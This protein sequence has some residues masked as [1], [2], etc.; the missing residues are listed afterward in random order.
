MIHSP[1]F[2]KRFKEKPEVFAD[3]AKGLKKGDSFSTFKSK[4]RTGI[5]NSKNQG[6]LLKMSNDQLYEMWTKSISKPSIKAKANTKAELKNFKGQA[7]KPKII[8]VKRKGKAYKRTV[9]KRW[10]RTTVFGIKTAS[11]VKPKSKE[12][13]SYVASIVKATG[14]TRQAVVK[15]I[16]RERRKQQK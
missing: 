3:F 8:F 14:R 15:K 9:P 2:D 4:F 11:K 12:Y 6:H 7:F 10:E 13:N 5:K 1:R 16:Q